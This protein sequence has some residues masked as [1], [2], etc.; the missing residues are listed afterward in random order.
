MT[1]FSF[2]RWRSDV[3]CHPAYT[4]AINSLGYNQLV[5]LVELGDFLTFGSVNS[6]DYPTSL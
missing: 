3:E 4:Y 1:G 2:C 5:T 6:E